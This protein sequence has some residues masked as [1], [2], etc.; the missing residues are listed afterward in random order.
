VTG[1]RD[2]VYERRRAEREAHRQ[3]TVRRRRVLA[4]AALAAV[5]ALVVAIVFVA[6]GG[7][8]DDGSG[9]KQA[10]APARSGS[11]PEGRGATPAKPAERVPVSKR[12]KPVP[13][14]M[15]H[16]INDPPGA[17][18]LPEL[19]VAKSDFEAQMEWLKERRYS[20]VT[21]QQVYDLWT[22]GVPLPRR[23][24]VISF[25]DGY[26]S[27]WA[28]ALPAMKRAGMRGVLN[29][30]LAELAQTSQGGI[31]AD[32]VRD[33][34]TAGWEIDSHT[35]THPDLTALDDPALRRELVASR[36]RI[37]TLFKVPANFFCYP[38]GR[39]DPRVVAAVKAAGYLGATTTNLGNAGPDQLYTLNRVRINR[40]DGLE[41]FATKMQDLRGAGVAPA[42]PSFGGTEG[43]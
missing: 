31:S 29:L 34:Q 1:P 2:P 38:A 14:L 24:V 25:D 18:G 19:Y 12:D 21:M 13:I 28:N 7:G 6:A 9:D 35:L 41:G 17:G 22:K 23:P 27:I 39:Y 36:R 15:Y 43:A 4:A 11:A 40:S 5:V 37:R 42:P 20:A 8:G 3:A 26:R 10:P 30:E 33:L 16:V 32:Q